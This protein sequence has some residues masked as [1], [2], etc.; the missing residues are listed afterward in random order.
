MQNSSADTTRPPKK[1]KVA[2][3]A[4]VAIASDKKYDFTPGIG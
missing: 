4:V 2:T 1:T 3:A